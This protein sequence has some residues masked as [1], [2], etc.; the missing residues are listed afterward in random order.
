M[1]VLRA[2]I[3]QQLIIYYLDIYV[4]ANSY[5]DLDTR[6]SSYDTDLSSF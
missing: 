2:R 4:M 1:C 5:N 6:S 3:M